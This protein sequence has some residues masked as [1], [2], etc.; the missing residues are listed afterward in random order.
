MVHLFII[1]A[2][3]NSSGQGYNLV[4]NSTQSGGD[5]FILTQ[6]Q[7]WQNGAIWYEEAINISEPFSLQFTINFGNLDA[8]G[9]DG[10]VFVM[11][12]VGNEVIGVPGAGMGFEGFSPSLGVEFDSFQNVS[13]G[14]P[15]F[16]HLAINTNG[17]PNH[18][19]VGN[20]AGPVP[21]S[22]TSD[23]VE[24]GQDY[25]IDIS[26]DPSS[27][28]FSVSVNCEVRLQVNVNLEFF[29]FSGSQEVFWGF[30]GATGGEFNE[31]RICLDPF[32]LGLPETFAGC[33][34]QPVQL[35]APPASF[36]TVTWEPA[37]FL[38]DPNSFSPIATVDQDTEF[39]LTFED[40]CGNVQTEQTTIVIE[41]PSVDL[42]EDIAECEGNEIL[43]SASGNFDDIAWSDGSQENTLPVTESGTYWV[44]VV[45]GSC[46]VSDTVEVEV[47]PLPS[48]NG[49]TDVELCS[50]EEFVFQLDPAID[51]I[52]WF[53]GSNDET[54]TFDQSGTYSF[55]LFQGDCSSD[56]ELGIN[57]IDLSDFSLGPDISICEGQDVVV[58]AS[59]T[60]EGITWSDNSQGNDLTVTESGTYWA[61]VFSGDCEA[62]DTVV[63]QF[64]ASP[65]YDGELN[66]DLCEGEE[67]E[68]DLGEL[69]Y[70][71]IWFDGSDQENRVFDQ[72]GEYPF[73]LTDGDCTAD[74]Q[75]EVTVTPIPE[76][77]LG[78][79]ITICEGA[80]A[81]LTVVTEDA[82]I[83][84]NT[85]S[86]DLSISVTDEGTFW[87]LAENNDCSFSD[88]IA[89]A[90]TPVPD[91]ILSGTESLCPGEDGIVSAIS[92]APV[93]WTTGDTDSEILIN[94]PGVYTATATNAEGCSKQE[95]VFVVGLSLPRIDPIE[96]LLKCQEEEF[97]LVKAVSSDDANLEW[98]N[99]SSANSA[100][101]SDP[102]SHYVELSNA[103][104]RTREEFQ[105]GEKECFDLFFLPTA[106]TPDGDGLNDLL[107]PQIDDFIT[108]E[109]QIFNR[110]GELVFESKD[111]N[112]GWNGS[113]QN[114]EYFC[115]A[116][117]YGVRYSI[118]FGE[119]I[120]KEGFGSVLLI[121]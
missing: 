30:T 58:S 82:S 113:F 106:F 103:C 40:L 93:N 14:D 116:G 15:A 110:A 36:G 41:E 35:E 56:Y 76:F 47:V 19:L 7:Q 119:N 59:G 115:P 4:G 111:P 61:D 75:V 18:N 2:S 17:N 108:Y 21:I 48:Y 87:A 26:W 118:D 65:S 6:A 74:Y 79:D 29:V 20:L 86:S 105:L 57:V 46:Q 8:A 12:Q 102:G 11:Q 45:S 81:V 77:D 95:S 66:A 32:I 31:Q 117:V 67:F 71:I 72:D 90:T 3:L 96:D 13:F 112:E 83:T 73:E 121:R 53:D 50:N 101:Y 88:T 25:V 49:E 92:S 107:K 69:N 34:G 94:Q 23:N 1:L 60:F 52:E 51:Q 64:D 37:E 54:R 89:V 43:L 38:D 99:G 16:D 9:A 85:G 91:L 42:G 10:M 80:T 33:A 70:E 98:S 100:R 78:P 24:D 120:L 55:E 104:G 22:P 28:T 63:V 97:I 84:W 27:N 5:C 44:D 68:F 109:L 39:T 114:D 62:T